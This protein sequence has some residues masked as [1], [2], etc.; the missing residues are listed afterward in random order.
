MISLPDIKIKNIFNIETLPNFCQKIG[1]F[2]LLTFFGKK[3][4]A[5]TF[6]SSIRF[7]QLSSKIFVKLTML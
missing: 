5:T 4:M 7:N 3:V 1:A 2:A 6:M